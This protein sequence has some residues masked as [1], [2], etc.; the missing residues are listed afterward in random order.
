[1]DKRSKKERTENAFER[2]GVTDCFPPT[3][4]SPNNFPTNHFGQ[5]VGWPLWKENVSDG[6]REKGRGKEIWDGYRVMGE[7]QR[8]IRG[9]TVRQSMITKKEKIVHMQ[10]IVRGNQG[11]NHVK[12]IRKSATAIIMFIRRC[13]ARKMSEHITYLRGKAASFVCT[14]IIQMRCVRLKQK[15]EKIQAV[16]HGMCSFLLRITCVIEYISSFNINQCI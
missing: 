6:E 7:M 12:S 1:M 10:R 4:L 16:F 14:Q 5:S 15:V 13:I 9:S 3:S 11:R 2:L 8:S